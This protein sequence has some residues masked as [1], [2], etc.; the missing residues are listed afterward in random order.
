MKPTK[1]N[2]RLAEIGRKIGN[3]GTV[4][5]GFLEDATYPAS[6]VGAD[7]LMKGL[8]KLNRVGPFQ[9]GER[10]SSLRD[11]R[12]ARK[13]R[14]QSFVGPPKPP[15]TLYVATVAWWNNNG[16]ARIPARPFFSNMIAE[17]SPSW[18]SELAVM[19]RDSGYNSKVALNLLGTRINDQLVHA[20][21]SW[22][23]DNSPLTVAIKGFNKGLIDS[24]VMQRSTSFEV[25]S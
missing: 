16:N 18:G 7:R 20:I 24:G 19:F 15:V 14:Q 1:L 17:K 13:E 6:E 5:V 3:G 23:A 10:P 4:R 21:V 8:D 12:K 9:K 2:K 22:P 11:Y 25:R